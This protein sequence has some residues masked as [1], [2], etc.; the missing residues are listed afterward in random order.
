MADRY[1]NVYIHLVFA[2]KNRKALLKREWRNDLF[3]FTS[4]IV[5]NRGHYPLAINGH[6]DHIHILFDYSLAELI[7]SVR[8]SFRVQTACK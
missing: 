3:A 4:G 8:A 1:K 6:Y 2:V 5:K 7:T